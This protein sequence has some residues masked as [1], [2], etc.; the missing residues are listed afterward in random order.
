M[1]A[2]D[3]TGGVA[4]NYVLPAASGAPGQVLAVGV[5]A[6]TALNQLVWATAAPTLVTSYTLTLYEVGG[7][8]STAEI[9]GN[10]YRSGTIMILA[11]QGAATQMNTVNSG[12]VISQTALPAPPGGRVAFALPIFDATLGVNT[13]AVAYIDSTG[14]VIL[15]PDAAARFAPGKTLSL[16]GFTLVWEAAA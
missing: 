16:L 2:R 1:S 10:L 14:F 3:I 12:G 11:V 13:V 7:D 8:G 6:P 4:V 15:G 9:S 5:P